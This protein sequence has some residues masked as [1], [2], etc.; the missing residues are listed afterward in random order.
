MDLNE[1]LKDALIDWLNYE[2][3]EKIKDEMNAMDINASRNLTQSL[4]VDHAEAFA[5]GDVSAD[6]MM[7]AYWK[8]VNYGVNGSKVNN[9]APDYPPAPRGAMTFK[10]SILEWIP[11][12]GFTMPPSFSSYESFAYAIMTN[13]KKYGQEPRPFID[14]A[15]E[16]VN[17]KQLQKAIVKAYADEIR[18]KNGY[19]DK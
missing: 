6:I 17:T 11:Q 19:N 7:D 13:I 2:L 16:N 4:I 12:R 15:M 1:D 8:Y 10:D 18:R 5:N 3:I 9:G 14:R